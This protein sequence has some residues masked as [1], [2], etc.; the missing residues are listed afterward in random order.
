MNNMH[1]LP[2]FPDGLVNRAARRPRQSHNRRALFIHVRLGHA[3]MGTFSSLNEN[4]RRANIKERRDVVVFMVPP[5]LSAPR[6]PDPRRSG[7]DLT[8]L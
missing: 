3:F 8:F 5:P 6:N 7:I 2:C 4:R 1:A